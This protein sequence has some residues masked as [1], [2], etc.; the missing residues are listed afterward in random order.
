MYTRFD[1]WDGWNEAL[2]GNLNECYIVHLYAEILGS[3]IDVWNK[4]TARFSFLNRPVLTIFLHKH[5]ST[6]R[7]LT[8]F[9]RLV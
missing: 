8:I 4:Q 5:D 7:N 3:Y 1:D 6:L 2:F 9:T